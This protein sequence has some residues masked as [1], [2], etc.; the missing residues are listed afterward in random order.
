[1][2]E[3]VALL[4][5][6]AVAYL[7]HAVALT[8]ACL[9][10]L[11]S[12]ASCGSSPP[13]VSSCASK[14]AEHWPAVDGDE[15]PAMAS[16]AG[17]IAIDDG[18]TDELPALLEQAAQ[19]E[20]SFAFS[21]HSIDGKSPGKRDALRFGVEKASG[22]WLLFTDV[23]CRPAGPNWAS[24]MTA[25]HSD[26]VA[27]VL[28]VSWPK[29]EAP[30]T[31]IARV[32]ALDALYIMRSYVGWAKRDKP[33]MGV[34]RNLAIRR[35]AFPGFS[36]EAATASGDDD[37]VIQA[38]ASAP[39]VHSSHRA[40]GRA[41]MPPCRLRGRIGWR[42]SAGT[43]PRRRITKPL[44]SGDW[45]CRRC[46]AQVRFWPRFWQWLFTIRYGLQVRCWGCG[47]VSCLTF[48]PSPKPI[49]PQILGKPGRFASFGRRG[50][51]GSLCR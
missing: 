16:E 18:S 34:G 6:C 45:P 43:G 36:K 44:T 9:R 7:A 35:S 50:A 20:L 32:Q 3:W 29:D 10:A 46:C 48:G 31:W 26:D 12:R 33:Y 37:M 14:D 47:W 24:E 51:H 1:M 4:A 13:S 39:D 38:L 41:W 25:G 22:Q 21:Y 28:G 15:G 49:K 30:A 5:A 11:R 40:P 2:N 17:V 42:K 8:R 19:D 23:D 27:A